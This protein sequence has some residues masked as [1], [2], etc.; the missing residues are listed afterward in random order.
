MIPFALRAAAAAFIAF[1]AVRA[2]A[3]DSAAVFQACM[4][5]AKATSKRITMAAK[6]DFALRSIAQ[7]YARVGAVDQFDRTVSEIQSGQFRVELTFDLLDA[8]RPQNPKAAD[9]LLSLATK[10]TEALPRTELRDRYLRTIAYRHAK[11]GNIKEAVKTVA[12]IDSPEGRNQSLSQISGA[13]IGN[14]D[15]DGATATA[16]SIPAGRWR[17]DALVLLTIKKKGRELAAQ[18]QGPNA[19]VTGT[20][21]AQ[22]APTDF[23]KSLESARL[24]SNPTERGIALVKLGSEA[25][26]AGGNREIARTA[27]REA[28]AAHRE[29]GEGVRLAQVGTSQTVSGFVDDALETAEDVKKIPYTQRATPGHDGLVYLLIDIAEAQYRAGQRNT[30]RATVQSIEAIWFE[31]KHMVAATRFVSAA[32]NVSDF[33]LARRIAAQVPNERPRQGASTTADRLTATRPNV[34]RIIAAGLAKD[35]DFD[36]AFKTLDEINQA[37]TADNALWAA[38]KALSQIAVEQM[39]K[40]R[41]PDA[42]RTVDRISDPVGQVNALADMAV[43]AKLGE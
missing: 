36:G 8:I 20:P 37:S 10:Y 22:P 17:N 27:Y 4:E 38:D 35:G 25:A 21:R 11:D 18:T 15:I 23:V 16:E 5:K 19:T 24:I 31:H 9:A 6:R 1:S 33:D 13:Q 7:T 2:D 41:L 26:R 28:R 42:F 32:T 34:L 43:K 29:N 39:R 40:G 3:A 30:A 12:L 14:N